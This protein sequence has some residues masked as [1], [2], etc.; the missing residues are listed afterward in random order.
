MAIYTAG[1]NVIALM[2]I[3]RFKMV[4]TNTIIIVA[5]LAIRL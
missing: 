2:V 4:R 3:Y 1:N 5:A